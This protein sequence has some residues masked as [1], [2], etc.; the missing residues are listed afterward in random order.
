M[1]P[2]SNGYADANG[3]QLYH[4]I[5]GEGEPLVPRHLSGRNLLKKRLCWLQLPRNAH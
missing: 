1:K 5:N 4:E 2:V 3:I